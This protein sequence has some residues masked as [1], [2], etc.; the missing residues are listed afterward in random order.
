[1]MHKAKISI[2]IKNNGNPQ[3]SPKKCPITP[4]TAPINEPINR[5]KKI[6]SNII[7]NWEKIVFYS[8]VV[9]ALLFFLLYLL[10]KLFIFINNLY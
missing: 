2:D 3:S 6:I 4:I 1:M 9:I 8:L 10:V 7:L 5:T